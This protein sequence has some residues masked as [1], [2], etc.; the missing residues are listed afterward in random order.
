M[1]DQIRKSIKAAI[2]KL[3][4]SIEVDFSV[5]YAPAN[6]DAD[7]ASNAAM[8]LAKKLGRK[9]MAVAGEIAGDIGEIW[10]IRVASP[11]FIN[12]KLKEEQLALTVGQVRNEQKNFGKVDLG[13]NELA[14][15]EYFQLNVAKPPHVGHLRSAVIGDALKRILQ[16]V[17]YN[18]VSDT[19]VGDWGTQFGL[20][21]LAH[22]TLPHEKEVDLTEL[23]RLYIEINRQIE[24]NPELREEAK[25]EFVKLEKGDEENRRMWKKFLALS[26]PEY[27]RSAKMLE[28]LWPFDYD[29][30]E[31]FYEDK[32]PEILRR[33]EEM[34]LLITGKTGEKYVDLEKHGLGRLICVKSD[35]GT[36]YELRDLATLAYRYDE[37]TKK[38]KAELAW[39]LYVVD[40]R[41]SHDFKQV[42][43]TMELLGY[44]ISKSKHIAHG[45]MSL[46]E[47]KI[48]SRKGNVVFLE[49]LL[50]EAKKRALGIIEEK[51]PDL[52]NKDR[53]AEQVGLAAIKYFDLKHNRHSDIVFDWQE[54]L[55]F[56]GNSGPYLQYT[57]ARLT[58]I[59]KKAGY[60]PKP[61]STFS[62]AEFPLI[63]QMAIFED[64]IRDTATQFQPNVLA[65][66]LYVFAEKI[67]YFYHNF[68]V[69][70][71][72][73]KETANLR[74][75]VVSACTQV[76]KNGLYLLGIDAPEEM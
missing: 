40:V 76:L 73:D 22:K 68:P 48:S 8:V 63:R 2:N 24:G 17:G 27:K 50:E 51:N 20:L 39:N 41:Q 9:P 64:V 47:G 33:L 57:H 18:A 54:A 7:Y 6:I 34:K 69:L 37:I 23:N 74:L 56:E 5:D 25:Q 11:G 12:F 67:N 42:F 52:K 61:A 31:Q 45:F 15:V 3:Y 38:E 10:E 28:L 70:Q 16:F 58:N 30:G 60:K 32:M 19:H 14:M 13:H 53:V 65:N 49:A 21:L 35:G 66:Y 46:P 36:T 29:L 75:D 55:S 72:T 43:K 59:L 1:K 62:P 26:K 44:D 4:P 71:A